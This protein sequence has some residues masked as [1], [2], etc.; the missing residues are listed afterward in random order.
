MLSADLE[1]G[2]IC[3]RSSKLFISNHV[4]G[5]DA[6]PLYSEVSS[7]F[8]LTMYKYTFV[9]THVLE[10]KHTLT[11]TIHFVKCCVLCIKF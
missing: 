5:V 3:E 9:C 2:I 10:D 8:P 1:K 7:S 4:H 6:K 11:L